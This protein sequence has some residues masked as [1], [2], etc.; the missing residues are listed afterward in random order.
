M[1][2]RLSHVTAA[3][4]ANTLF[5]FNVGTTMV[6]TIRWDSRHFRLEHID[7]TWP[8]TSWLVRVYKSS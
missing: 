4:F 6:P 8:F 2:I 1:T 7:P 3:C 5:K